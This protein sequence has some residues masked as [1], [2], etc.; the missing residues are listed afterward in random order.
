MSVSVVF[1]VQP[2]AQQRGIIVVWDFKAGHN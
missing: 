2:V 1:F